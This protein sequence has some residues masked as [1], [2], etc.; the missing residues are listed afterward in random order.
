MKNLNDCSV[1]FYFNPLPNWLYNPDTYQILDV[2]QA[3][4]AHYGYSKEEFLTLTIND[5]CTKEDVGRLMEAHIDIRNNSGNIFLGTFSH[6]KKSGEH[7]WMKLN[8]QM[9][10]HMGEDNLLMVC[11]DITDEYKNLAR[12]EE[13][14]RKLKAA[15]AIAN[16]GYWRLEL[17]ADSLSWTN[18]VFNIWGRDKNLFTVNYES[19]YNTIHPDDRELF[20]K[21][22]H[23]SF[24]GEKNLDFIHRILLPDNSIR[25]VHE[26]GRLVKDEQGKAIAFEG[27]VQD[28]TVKRLEEQ[29]LKLLESVITNTNDAILI[30]EAE[31]LDDP[32]PRIIYVNEAFTRM[33]GYTPE[34]VIGKT[35]RILQGPNSDKEELKKLSKALRNWES[36]EITTINY[37]KNGEEFW[38]NFSVSPVADE[39]GWYTHWI[40]IER[41]VTEQKNRELEKDLLA[42]ISLIFNQNKDYVNAGNA[43]CKTINEFGKFDW[44]ELWT[45]NVEQTHLQLISHYMANPNDEIFYT[46]SENITTF[47]YDEGFIGKVWAG[48]TQMVWDNIDQQDDFLRKNAAHEIGLKS[49][50]GIPLIFNDEVFGVLNIGSKYESNYLQKYTKIFNQLVNYIGSELNRKKLENDLGRLYEAIPD[51]LCLVDFEGRFL[52]MNNAAFELLGYTKKEML[53]QTCEQFV[54]PE[55][56]NISKNEILRL[57]NGATTFKF[58]NRY[59]T[60]AGDIV[61]LSWIGNSNLDE[62]IIYASAKN[63]TEEKKLR[64]LK[65]QSN[66]LAKIGSW[67]LDLTNESVYWSDMVH[68]LHETDPKTFDLSLNSGINF[69]KEDF[70]LMVESKIANCI[71]TFE[72]FDFEAILVTAKNNERWVRVIGTAE[73]TNG[74]CKRVFG[75]FQDIHREK[76]L[77]LQIREILGSISD[78]FYATDKNWNFTYFNKEAENLLKTK[79]EEVLGK[80]IWDI[81]TPT[82]GTILEKVYLTVASTGKSSS[83]EYLYPGD[84]CWYEVNVYPSNGGISSYFKNINERK[85]AAEEKQKS[86]EEKI[87]IIESIGDAFFTMKKDFT[88]TYWNKTAEKLLGVKREQLIGKNLWDIFPDAVNLPSY[89]NYKKVIETGESITF[90]D[91]YGMW[92]EINAYPSDE[93]VS[94][95]FR[96]ITLKKEVDSRLVAAYEEKT[97]ILESIG[98]AFFAVDK[99]WVVTYWNK[100]AENVLGKKRDDITGKNLWV[101]YADAVH[102]DFYKQYHKAM[103]TGENVTFEEYYPTLKKWFEVT[104]Y[105]NKDGLSVYFKDIT[106]RKETDIQI[107]QANERFEKVTQATT[108]AIWDWD[109]EKD[110]FYRGNGFEK[111]FGYEVRKSFKKSEFWLDSF[112]PDDLTGIRESL[113]KSL[114]DNTSDYWKKEYRIIHSSGD[115]KTVV[116][117]GMIIRDENGKATRVVGAITD[118]TD[119]KRYEKELQHLN[120]MLKKHIHELEFTNEQLEQFAF[121]ASHDLQEPLRMISSF[122]NQ[123]QRKYGNQLDDKAHQYINFATDGA[124]RMKQIILD[125]LDYSRA[126]KLADQPETINLNDLLDEYKLLRRRLIEEK[127]VSLTISQLPIINCFKAPLTQTIHCLLDNALK[128][129]KDDVT[130]NVTVG[131]DE[132]NEHWVFFV[133]DNG[134]G[135]DNQFF[136]K[137]F[138]IFQRLH[139]RDKYSGTGIGL[140]IAKKHVESWGGKI[141]LESTPGEGSTF[142]F[143]INKHMK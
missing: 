94:V 40:A 7:I 96:D 6:T 55:D 67:E 134:I 92:L 137:I 90:E 33:T 24:S 128:Y 57:K 68:Q 14:E 60:K 21:E 75:S 99:N 52:K 30:T 97:K 2:N 25:W 48:R 56:V 114:L 69:Y 50:L 39:T 121:I 100:E 98:D 143:T 125:L 131:F 112:H 10:N 120:E 111:L 88:V 66:K 141:W 122:L 104:A 95:F 59:V 64:E 84:N 16:V 1:L 81:F 61:W 85:K 113:Q 119:R 71:A 139:N 23:A 82:K 86:A 8:T 138:V 31:P 116:D 135:I 28:I 53:Y 89:V 18:E 109:I 20:E 29:R 74:K 105:P 43:L 5:L 22:Q 34:E 17:D 127:N 80:N 45:A 63:I 32:G 27:T 115:E 118:I 4:I 35:P 42:Q 65:R 87:K 91:H 102:L 54:H 83:F 3:A 46:I 15:S 76:T 19:F 58:E 106:L 132:T 78:A 9:I 140:S 103:D 37:K 12:L 101:E 26:K 93:G 136:E 44:V 70:R 129:S 108:D 130:P 107:L 77:E 36:C 51:I 38:I 41:D 133:K 13:T 142:Y 72:P 110:T 11:T 79:S 126:G 49:L 62:G 47:K 124:K 73:H 123:L 117:K